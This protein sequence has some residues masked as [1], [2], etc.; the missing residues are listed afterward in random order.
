[1]STTSKTTNTAITEFALGYYIADG[2]RFGGVLDDV[3][4]YLRGLTDDD[5][6]FLASM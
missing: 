3:R 2:E 4:I 1:T 5:I 6:L